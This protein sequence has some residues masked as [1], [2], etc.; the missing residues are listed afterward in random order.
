M[1]LD[2]SALLAQAAAPVLAQVRAHREQLEYPGRALLEYLEGHVYD[3]GL[4]VRSWCAACKVRSVT[5]S[6]QVKAVIG[7]PLALYLEELRVET[8][9]RL[10]VISHG[11]LACGEVGLFVGYGREET[12]R[13][14][15]ER[16]AGVKPGAYRRW[17]LGLRLQ[18]RRPLDPVWVRSGWLARLAEGAPLSAK[19]WAVV[20][21]AEAA[22]GWAGLEVDCAPPI[23]TWE[24]YERES[25]ELLWSRSRRLPIGVLRQR[26]L[27][28]FEYQT[29]ALCRELLSCVEPYGLEEPALGVETAELA[30]E[31]AVAL[32]P[33]LG[34][35]ELSSWLA[36]AWAW[37]GWARRRAGDEAGASAGFERAKACLAEH[38]APAQVVAEVLWLEAG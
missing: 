32:K 2:L 6:Q 28:G 8:A 34:A 36:R 35:A 24:D 7:T 11:E 16:R 3:P 27:R 10:M 9:M 13:K 19:V 12:F 29:P 33:R 4:R 1:A 23:E 21:Q 30:L 37:L 22:F 18:G 5:A 14:V 38:P 26:V 15:F 17:V 20:E 31:Q 25:A